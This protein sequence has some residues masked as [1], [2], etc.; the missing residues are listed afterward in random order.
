MAREVCIKQG[1]TTVCTGS[2]LRDCSCDPKPDFRDP[3]LEIDET[4]DIGRYIEA[5][6]ANG[7]KGLTTEELDAKTHALRAC[8]R[9]LYA[10]GINVREPFV[11]MAMEPAPVGASGAPTAN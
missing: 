2:P 4:V 7:G 1:S 6:V 11:I 5:V 8:A 3:F 9:L 10:P